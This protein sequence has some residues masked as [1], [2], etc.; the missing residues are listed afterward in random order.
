MNP[1][2]A[3]REALSGSRA[4]WGLLLRAA[5]AYLSQN[6][7]T[8]SARKNLHLKT[9]NRS[10]S[11]KERSDSSEPGLEDA[12]KQPNHEEPATSRITSSWK[13]LP[14]SRFPKPRN[15]EKIQPIT[16]RVST[17]SRDPRTIG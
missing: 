14:K 1:D 17:R 15:F 12:A 9:G 3:E 2:I 4:S 8:S 16:T 10:R 11:G 5:L 6:A 7:C 13:R